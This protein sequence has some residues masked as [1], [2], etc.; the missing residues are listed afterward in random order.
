MSKVYASPY[1]RRSYRD[2]PP[3]P[4]NVAEVDD[5]LSIITNTVID[6]S[7]KNEGEKL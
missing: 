7:F 5:G 3:S 4:A 2:L 1:H 6:R